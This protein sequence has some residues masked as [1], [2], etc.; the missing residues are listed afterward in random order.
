MAPIK[1][2]PALGFDIGV[3]WCHD[4]PYRYSTDESHRLWDSFRPFGSDGRV[5]ECRALHLARVIVLRFS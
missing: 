5:T 2:Q 4:L 1:C 3:V